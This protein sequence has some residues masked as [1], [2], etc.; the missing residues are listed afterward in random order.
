GG[1]RP[2]LIL[3]DIQ[4][5]QIADVRKTVTAQGLPILQEAPMITMRLTVLKGELIEDIL[6]D[7]TR[8][9]S[10]GLLRWEFRTTY[11]D[12]LFESEKVVAGVW[13]GRLEEEQSVIPISFE[14]GAAQRLLLSVGD[15]LVWNVQGVP[16]TTRIASLRKVDWQRIQANFMVVFPQGALEYAPQIYILATKAPTTARSADLQRILV[17]SFPN[18]SIIDLA[19]V[20]STLDGFLSKISFVIRFM[21]FFSIFTGLIVLTSAVITSR[22]QRVQES[23]LLRTLG[24]SRKQ[25][26]KIMAV[27]YIFLGGLAALTGLLLSY[28]GGWALAYF[29]FDSLFLPT[30]LPFLIVL[31]LVT[32]VTVLIGM[33]NSRGILDRPPLEVMR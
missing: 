14:E 17:R 12:T 24:A 13:I 6:S 3:F 9:V 11:R 33:L 4:P 7:S 2:N 27:E 16:L 20:L 29:V 5:D 30:V 8:D 23:V 15:T 22:Y 32:G 31:V 1:N 26:V 25:V 18:V 28:A 21:A 19:L 10:R